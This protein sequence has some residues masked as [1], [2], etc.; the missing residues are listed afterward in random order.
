[1]LQGT[2]VCKDAFMICLGLGGNYKLDAHGD[3]DVNLTVICT[4][5]DNKV[6]CSYVLIPLSFI[7]DHIV[8]FFS[9]T[10]VNLYK[11]QSLR[12]SYTKNTHDY[13]IFYHITIYTY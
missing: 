7:S 8:G 2:K 4:N 11:Q 13:M 6:L 3:R 9:V 5:N 1:M 12:P 10:L